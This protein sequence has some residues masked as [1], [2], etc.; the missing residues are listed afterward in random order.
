[1]RRKVAEFPRGAG[2][3][4]MKD[5]AGQVVY[6]GKAVDLRARVRSYFQAG[7]GEV[8][9][10]TERFDE[11]AD[12]DVVVTATE[13]EALILESNFIKQF[14]PKYNIVRS[15]NRLS[16]Q[17]QQDGIRD[18]SKCCGRDHQVDGQAGCV[19]SR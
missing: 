4:L 14:R 7:R 13:S 5:A 18:F 15:E 16:A 9:L 1:M 10:I 3:Y 8:R 6:V 19:A 2:V 17:R 11:V 12:I